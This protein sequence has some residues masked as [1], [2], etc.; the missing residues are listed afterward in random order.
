MKINVLKKMAML[1]HLQRGGF[2]GRLSKVLG[3]FMSDINAIILEFVDASINNGI[4]QENGNSNQAN[5]FYRVIQKKI[6]WLNE[7]GEICNPIFLK[8][9]HHENDY[10]RYYTACALL[11][12]KNND[13]LD[14]LLALTEKK[15]LV[16]FS[17]KMTIKE[18]KEG[19]I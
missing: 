16:G 6:K 10:V 7:H 19:N 1:Y 9:L 17:S 18:Y 2:L 5:K 13:A 4:A 8:L 11:H 15:G 12:A 14:T 3:G